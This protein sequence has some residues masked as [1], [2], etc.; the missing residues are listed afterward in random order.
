MKYEILADINFLPVISSD[1]K[2]KRPERTYQ[3]D[4]AITV[5]KTI[6]KQLTKKRFFLRIGPNQPSSHQLSKMFMTQSFER[7]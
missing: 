2:K 5:L 3:L 7:R 6:P 4:V 1:A